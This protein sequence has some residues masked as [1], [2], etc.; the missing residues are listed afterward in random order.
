MHSQKCA[1]VDWASQEN[2]ATISQWEC[3]Q[4]PNVRWHYQDGGPGYFFLQANHS[5]KCAVVFNNSMDDGAII[6]QWACNLGARQA[7][8]LWQQQPVGG[9][10]YKIINKATNKCM[11]VNGA[12]ND[13]GAT[14]SQWDCVDQPNVYWQI[15]PVSRTDDSQ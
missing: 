14:I 3:L 2:G 11:Q 13:D 8:F 1:Q 10:Y 6:G 5:N 15:P 9:G 12:S 7:I 4:Q